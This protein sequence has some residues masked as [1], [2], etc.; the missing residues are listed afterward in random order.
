MNRT[1]EDQRSC[2]DCDLKTALFKFL[3]DQEIERVNQCKTAVYYKKGETIRKQGAVLTHVISLN[4]GLAKVYLEGTNNKNIILAIIRPSSFIGGPGIFVDHKNHF[5]VTSLTD[6]CACFIELGIFK[7]L[8]HKNKVFAE[9]YFK[10]LG[11]IT[12]SAYNRLINLTQKQMAGRLADTLIYLS[13][14]IFEARSFNMVLSKNDLAELSGMSRD[15]VV[16]NL[17]KFSDEGL[18]KNSGDRIE[19]LNFKS[20]EHINDIG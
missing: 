20:L 19:I 14:E 16:R 7:E 4:T 3:S 15:N 8:L 11:N 18:I 17:K 10:H 5:T 6:S 13:E 1:F 12:L 9:E 2:L